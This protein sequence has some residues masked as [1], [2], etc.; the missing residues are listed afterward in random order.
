MSWAQEQEDKLG[1][2]FATRSLA[3]FTA[4]FSEPGSALSALGRL[5][6]NVES[7]YPW[8]VLVLAAAG[9]VRMVRDR[10][11]IV[12]GLCLVGLLHIVFFPAGAVMHDYWG[13]ALLPGVS[14]C[15]AAGSLMIARALL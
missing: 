13:F 5:A 7:L 2:A 4:L 3:F 9:L 8:P 11:W 6:A 15:A 14:V 12:L 10:R 1:D